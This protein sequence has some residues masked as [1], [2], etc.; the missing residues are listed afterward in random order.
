V[1]PGVQ[2]VELSPEDVAYVNERQV[3]MNDI[4]RR[5]DEARKRYEDEIAAL[6]TELKGVHEGTWAT[7]GEKHG[8]DG[9]Q[10]WVVDRSYEPLGRVFMKR[11]H[12][13]QSD[14]SQAPT[15]PQA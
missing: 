4:E 13:Q 5:A 3:L 2:C 7:L 8:L 9:N 15:A 11:V 1:I 6:N 14:Q 12:P 10:T